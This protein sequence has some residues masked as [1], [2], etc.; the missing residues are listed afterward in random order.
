MF[1]LTVSSQPQNELAS[2]LHSATYPDLATA[3]FWKQEILE[4]NEWNFPTRT[5]L[6]PERTEVI[7]AIPERIEVIPAVPEQL[8]EQGQVVIPAQPEQTIVY[9]A[10]PEQT[11][12]YPA[13]EKQVPDV[14]I[15]IEDITA[16]VAYKADIEKRIKRIEFGKEIFAELATRNVNRLKAGTTTIEQILA[17]EAKLALVQRYLANSTLEIALQGLISLDVPEIPESEK[18]YFINKIQNYLTNE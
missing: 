1:K 10:I 3:E 13:F 16:E 17:A 6:V 15:T 8:D 11:I 5:E 2:I 14:T 7:P 9:P 12:V 18:L 4:K